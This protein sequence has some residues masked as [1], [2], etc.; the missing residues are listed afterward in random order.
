MASC[1]CN[2][3]D[4]GSIYLTDVDVAETAMLPEVVGLKGPFSCLNLARYGICW[5]VM[6]AAED[7]WFRSREYGMQRVQFGR[8]LAATQLYQKKLVDMQTEI[9]LGLQG[10]LQLGHLLDT[11]NASSELISMLKR[12]NCE[13]AL[14]IAR[15]ARDMHGANGIH[16]DYQVM[17]HLTNLET[18]NT[19]EGTADIHMLILGRAQT[20]LPAFN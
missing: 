3:V 18:V 2:Q 15:T 10:C 12:N 1:P 6:G 5:G 9:A 17:R 19:Y 8:P 13:K 4:T 20:G 14:A 16:Q 7:C 11:G